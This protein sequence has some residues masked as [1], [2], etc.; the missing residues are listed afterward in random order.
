MQ[1]LPKLSSELVNSLKTSKNLLA[2]SAGSD[3]SALFYILKSL[4]VDFDIALVN[5]KTRAQSDAEEAYAKDLAKEFDIKVFTLTCKLE[6][7]NFEHNARGKRYEFFEQIINEHGYTNLIMAHHLNDKLEWFLMQ[8]GR[9]AGLVEMLGMS[10]CEQRDNYNIIRPLINISKNELLE[11]LH[12]N[13]IKH[14]LDESNLN[15]KYKRNT[16]RATYAN[17]FLKEYQAGVIKSFEYLQN[18]AKRLMIED[19]KNIKELYILD[20]DSDD[21]KNIR[22]IDKIIKRLG[23]LLSNAQREEILRTRDCVISKKI[24]VTFKDTKIYICPYVKAVMDKKF[25]E[26]CRKEKIPLK[27]RPYLFSQHISPSELYLAQK[28]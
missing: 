22:A 26:S 2:F 1:K 5:Y 27:I 19:I 15:P 17:S 23:Y 10:E 3:S 9:G 14:F 18:D 20:E 28:P 4:H 11:F 21:L 25:K 16:I 8:L 7:S 12:V 6:K 13:N 24:V